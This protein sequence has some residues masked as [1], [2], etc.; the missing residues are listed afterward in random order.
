MKR[1]TII[2]ILVVLIVALAVTH[3]L[4]NKELVC[5]KSGE[6]ILE[7]QS[8]QSVSRVNIL[9]GHIKKCWD[10][11]Y[12]GGLIENESDID[13]TL[14]EIELTCG[15]G[16]ATST[17]TFVVGTKE[18]KHEGKTAILPDKIA[19]AKPYSVLAILSNYNDAYTHCRADAVRWSKYESR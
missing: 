14:V 5:E 3:V 18:E 15:T 2:E 10:K 6:R 16:T 1:K 7:A 19:I 11:H 13:I 8:E 12:F 9:D 4:F 17:N